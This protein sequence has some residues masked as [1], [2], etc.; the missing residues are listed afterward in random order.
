[1]HNVVRTVSALAVGLLV[2]GFL[3]TAGMAWRISRGP[4]QLDFLTPQLEATLAP[5]DGSATIDIGSTALEWDPIDRDLDVRVHDLRI[6]GP[7]G[8]AL[9]TLPAIAVSISPGPLL[10]GTVAPRAIELIDPR[11]HVVRAADGH[12]E[13]GIGDGPAADTTR[14]LGSALLGST[15][16]TSGRGV[17]A[18]PLLRVRNGEL[19]VDDRSPPPPG[20]RETSSWPRG[21]PAA[22]SRSST[23]SSTSIARRCRPPARCGADART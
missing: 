11:I 10:L 4:I 23:C 12:L 21:A 15:P 20:R 14:L 5:P 3:V 1:M 17:G 13:A 7:G 16:G 18:I 22:A 6:L 9:A 2:G 8:T 19:V